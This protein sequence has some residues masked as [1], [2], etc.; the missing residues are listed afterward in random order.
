M[1]VVSSGHSSLEMTH[2]RPICPRCR[3]PMWSFRPKETVDD[4]DDKHVFQCPRCEYS[5][6]TASKLTPPRAEIA[7]VIPGRR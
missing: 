1:A 3:A 5:Y 2:G 7:S 4:K 6:E